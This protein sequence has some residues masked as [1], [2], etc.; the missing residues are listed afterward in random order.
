LPSLLDAQ[1]SSVSAG[2]NLIEVK[3]KTTKL[4][5]RGISVLRRQ[6]EIRKTQKPRTWKYRLD[7]VNNLIDI[8]KL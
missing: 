1:Q 8:K 2:I 4:P 5:R 6:L 7:T 3:A